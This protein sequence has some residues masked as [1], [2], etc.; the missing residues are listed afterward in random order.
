MQ[1]NHANMVNRCAL[2]L[3]SY[4]HFVIVIKANISKTILPEAF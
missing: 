1:L 4:L 2:T 3:I